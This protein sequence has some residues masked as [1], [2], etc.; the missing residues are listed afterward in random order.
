VGG[1]G[2]RVGDEHLSA[3]VVEWRAHPARR[4]LGTAALAV[5]VAVLAAVLAGAALGSG[6]R[7]L[8]WVF[9]LLLL[10]SISRFLLPTTFV[11]DDDGIAVRHLG[12]TR[13]R[14]WDEIRRIELG[15]R[16]AL[17]SPFDA[18][19]A[20]DRFRAILVDLDG[21][22]PEA[23]AALERARDAITARAR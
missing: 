7:W 23:R 9:A 21:A 8:K 18:P 17:L 2:S 20:L 11:L 6:V 22:P 16:A 1:S 10:S 12:T 14:R 4:R 3:A 13:K 19:R 15:A 5:A